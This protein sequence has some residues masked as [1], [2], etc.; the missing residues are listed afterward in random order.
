MRATWLDA[1]EALRVRLIEPAQVAPLDETAEL[2]PYLESFLAH[3][4]L[5][6]GV[7]FEYL[8]A[9]SRLLPDE[10]IR[11]FYLDR[12]W[13]DRLVDGVISVGKIGTREQAHHQAHA[14]EVQAA[15]DQAEWQVRSRQRGLGDVVDL[16]DIEPGVVVTGFLLRSAAV[17]GWPHLEVRAFDR[18]LDAYP[19]LEQMEVARLPLL[20]LE[21]LSPALLIALFAGVPEL[22]WLEEPHH[23]VQ[24]GVKH[25]D[26]HIV[27]FRRTSSG[28]AD[29]TGPPVQ[30]PFRTGGRR[31]V[32]VAEL[33]ARLHSA[34]ADGTAMPQ[35][36]GSAMFALEVLDL[37]WR[38][39]FQS[40]GANPVTAGQGGF[41]STFTVAAKALDPDVLATVERL[42]EP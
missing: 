14:P 20:R 28:Q 22:V 17:S 35:Q 15:L 25:E 29:P 7:P 19:T 6:V 16:G 18:V 39:R 33:R 26:N 23:G 41:A 12:S 13:T 40:T 5:L 11:F 27:V 2:K 36:T 9:D 32:H 4:R 21:R 34:A 30:V 24:F 10:S 42:V 1:S 31:V 8:V 37:P 38:Q 3:L